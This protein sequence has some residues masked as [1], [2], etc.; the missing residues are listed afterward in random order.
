MRRAVG[1]AERLHHAGQ[2]AVG[3]TDAGIGDRQAKAARPGS[4]KARTAT[5]PPRGVN[6]T[7]VGQQVDEDLLHQALVAPQRR[8]LLLDLG[9]DANAGI[10]GPFR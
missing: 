5:L 1:L 7:A 10:G 9:G 8:Q 3:D 6:S 4:L 2:I